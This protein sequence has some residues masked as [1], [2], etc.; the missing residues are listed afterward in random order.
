MRPNLPSMGDMKLDL[1]YIFAP[2]ARG[3]QYFY[4]RRGRHRIAIKSADGRHLTPADRGF[5]AAYNR[6]HR[7]FDTNAPADTTRGTLG[8]LVTAY[9]ASGDFREKKP[10]TQSDYR[11]RMGLIAE[12]HGKVSVR[13]VGREF[14]I[15]IRDVLSA[16]PV[17][18]NNQIGAFSVLLSYAQDRPKEFLLPAQWHNPAHRI[19][20]L[21]AGPGYP[22][23]PDAVIDLARQHAY[24]QLRWL[25]DMALETGQRGQDVVVM[26]W[27]HYDGNMIS[28]VQQKTGARIW[29]PA[30]ARLRAT[31][32]EIRAGHRGTAVIL[33]NK[34]GRAWTEGHFRKEIGALMKRIGF[35]GY[36][37]HGL[38]KNATNRLLEAGCST[39]EAQSITG[40]T[41]LQMIELYG[42][43]A[44]R[45]T[46]AV[47]AISK[48]E[49][50]RR[51]KV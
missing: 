31:L 22:P 28:V 34:S 39:K 35:P 37:I 21:K 33:T 30:S 23:W 1:P 7:N 27:T 24:P 17:K 4:Y 12:L 16:Q 18:A 26:V 48:L 15:G 10:R 40:H 29:I 43:E 14:L 9:L 25:I 6:I 5:I 49:N 13:D 3:K 36:S 11:K 8:H 19:K 38:R 47:S 41:T 51:T 32:G 2:K 50:A 45:K 42:A 46:L 44:E 20:R